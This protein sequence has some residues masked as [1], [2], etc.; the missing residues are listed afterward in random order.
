MVRNFFEFDDG[1]V[2]GMHFRLCGCDFESFVAAW[3]LE[4]QDVVVVGMILVLK[5]GI[6]EVTTG[7]DVGDVGE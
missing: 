2:D 7:R 6:H 1:F 3:V 4:C 5:D